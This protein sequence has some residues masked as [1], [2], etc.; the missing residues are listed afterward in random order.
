VNADGALCA[1][2]ARGFRCVM[3][4]GY[5]LDDGDWIPYTLLLTFGWDAPYI[6]V[7]HVRGEYD[8]T[9]IRSC[10]A[11]SEA[12]LFAVDAVVWKAEGGLVEVAAD[13]LALPAPGDPGAPTR[14][15]RAPSRLWTPA[16]GAPPAHPS[17]S[18]L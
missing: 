18:S 15:I 17:F 16:D 7:L 12:N 11:D 8:V 6:D 3:A 5:S 13:L 10:S 1:L 9:G 14:V 2:T 4:P